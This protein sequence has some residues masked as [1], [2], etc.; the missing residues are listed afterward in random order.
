VTLRV[1]VQPRASREGLGAVREGTLT[2]R[3]T[4]PPVDGQ[5]NQALCRLLGRVFGVPPSSVAV[6]RG[7][8]ARDK[9]VRL[10][11]VSL[12]DARDRLQVARRA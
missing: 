3:V 8:S 9:V 7:A 12:A 11:G 10:A 4:A 1:R 2:V 6:V 5:A